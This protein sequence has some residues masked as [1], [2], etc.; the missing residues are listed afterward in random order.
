MS[1]LTS[2]VVYKYCLAEP[3][4]DTMGFHQRSANFD[5]GRSSDLREA[6]P[7]WRQI[8]TKSELNILPLAEVRPVDYSG[9]PYVDGAI[10]L[11][12]LGSRDD[13][14]SSFSVDAFASSDFAR[15]TRDFGAY[16]FM[17]ALD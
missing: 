14:S 6:R 11:C 15:G 13:P 5:Q 8:H 10:I 3:E 16:Y 9:L 2:C 1:S 4:L 7:E 17:S 12:G